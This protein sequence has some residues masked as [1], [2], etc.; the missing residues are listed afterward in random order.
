MRRLFLGLL[1]RP[2]LRDVEEDERRQRK[3][4][5]H[6][7]QDE[8][9]AEPVVRLVVAAEGDDGEEA[10]VDRVEHVLE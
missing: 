2:N 7:D 9:L 5:E 6:L 3:A 8:Q 4:H 1:R 10:V